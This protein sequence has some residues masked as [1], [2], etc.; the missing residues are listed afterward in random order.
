MKKVLVYW[1]VGKICEACLEQYA[2]VIPEFFIDIYSQ[3]KYFHKKAVK[4]PDEI[5][6]WDD[7]YIVIVIKKSKDAEKILENKG[8][9]KGKTN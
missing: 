8:L 9:H 7:Y 2:D 1:G 4:R 3:K 6:N 5:D